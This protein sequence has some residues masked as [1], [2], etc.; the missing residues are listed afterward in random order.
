MSTKK[1]LLLG[2][3]GVLVLGALAGGVWLLFSWVF[4]VTGE[5]AQ[6]ADRFFQ[7]VAE[8]K[9]AEAYQSSASAL[10]AQQDLDTFTAGVKRLGLT[11]CASTSW[12]S[13]HVVNNVATLEGS[14]TTR[15][16]GTVPLKVVLT[17]EGDAWR[18]TSVTGPAGVGAGGVKRP[19]PPEDR[20]RGLTTATLL[21]FNKALGAKD[22]TAFHGKSS[23]QL[24]QQIAPA[25]FLKEFQQFLDKKI[26]LAGIKDVQPVFEPAPFVDDEGVL[27]LSGFYPTQPV[28]VQFRLRYVYEDPDWKLLG[29][30][31]KTGD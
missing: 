21:D 25:R 23:R 10:R 7:L 16:G 11:E 27:T 5:A 18:V 6:A 28:R 15:Q 31:V 22:F 26:D 12:P 8:G 20:L 9:V 17:R 19:V 14:M 2:G 4:A 30:N 24:R 13:R 29:I 3:V 1:W